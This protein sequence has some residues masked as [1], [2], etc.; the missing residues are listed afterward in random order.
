MLPQSKVEAVTKA[1]NDGYYLKHFPDISEEKLKEAMVISKPSNGSFM[2]VS[3][4]LTRIL[5]RFENSTNLSAGLREPRF[6]RLMFEYNEM[7]RIDRI[8][9]SY[10]AC[11]V[12][13]NNMIIQRCLSSHY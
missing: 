10:L 2:Y 12:V 1:L 9:M 5:N 8:R 11:C 13:F 4:P 3:A 6:Q 7:T